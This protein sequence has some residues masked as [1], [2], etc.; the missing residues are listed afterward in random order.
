[1][2]KLR[3]AE[4]ELV[5][6]VQAGC[7]GVALKRASIFGRAPVVH[8]LSIAF[9]VWGFL[10]ESAPQDL[11]DLRRSMFAEVHNPHHYAEQ[12]AIVDAVPESTLRMAPQAVTSA[13]RTNWRSLLDVN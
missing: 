4:G 5:E 8:D 13:Y 2:G 7:I 6:D 3:L 9:T 12:R 11:I 10:D 1:V